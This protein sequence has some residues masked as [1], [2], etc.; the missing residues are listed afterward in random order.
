MRRRIELEFPI[1]QNAD[2]ENMRIS[3]EG[4]FVVYSVGRMIFVVSIV[5]PAI[6]KPLLY[7]VYFKWKKISRSQA[8]ALQRQESLATEGEDNNI[9][10]RLKTLYTEYEKE[11]NSYERNYRLNKLTEG[12]NQAS[13]CPRALLRSREAVAILKEFSRFTENDNVTK[14][15]IASMPR[16]GSVRRVS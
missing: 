1:S 11:M 13:G 16:I 14:K 15:G 7:P 9:I 5:L 8:A 2:I 6:I 10:D 12:V 3:S 4:N